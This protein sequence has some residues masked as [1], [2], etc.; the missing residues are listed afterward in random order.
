MKQKIYLCVS[1]EIAASEKGGMSVYS[2]FKQIT[3]SWLIISFF[4][5][6]PGK[7]S[8]QEMLGFIHSNY[9]ALGGSL[10][11]P[12]LL[13]SSRNYLEVNL[14]TFD[15][16]A[17]NDFA[18]I[19]SSDFTI[20]N[21]IAG[22]S[23]PVYD[24]NQNTV[25]YYKNK[26]RKN[27]L[28]NVRIL[29]PSASYQYGKHGFAVTTGFRYMAVGNYIPW[30]IPVMSYE[31][32]DHGPIQDVN[33]VD[34]DFDFNTQAWMEIGL[35]YAY[36]VYRF[37]DDQVTVGATLKGV[38]GY[39]GVATQVNNLDYI[40]LNDSTINFKNLNGQIGYAV[41]VDYE[42]NDYPMH[43]P[44][45]KGFGVGLDV[46]V[47]YTK[48]KYVDSKRFKE[49]CDQRYEDY[50]YR[51]GVSIIDIGRIKYKNNAQLHSFDD[52]SA[53]WQNF[54]TISYDN[55]N[56][57]VEELSDVF[58]GDPD[59][60]YRDNNFNIGLPMAVSVQFDYNFQKRENFYLGAY[61]IQPIRFNMHTLRRP[62]ELAVIPRYETKNLEISVPISLYEYRYPRVGL[63]ARFAFFTI[64]TEKIGTYLGF[65]DLTGLDIYASIKFNFGKGT[66]KIKAPVECLNGEYGYTNKQKKA[67]RTR[68]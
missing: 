22:Q 26:D 54:D 27:A 49:A 4:V 31:G 30:E 6:V 41:P 8:G 28:A 66:C 38:W 62:A 17:S 18:Y 20:W 10:T 42:N 37:L 16:F 53:Y 63:S 59:A 46:G 33:Y 43:D 52:V 61:W 65:G 48:R 34:Y 13:T 50:I 15:V 58:Y 3:A 24:E 12:S 68:K 47:T 57:V 21:A 45:F 1:C 36:D 29:G 23:P 64:G 51:I 5:L 55:V 2:K 60:S 25:L 7:M 11:N 14:I 40:I 35:S 32:L 67:Y 56:Q 9:N 39:A 19:P 44:L